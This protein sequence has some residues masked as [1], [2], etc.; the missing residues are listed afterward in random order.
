MPP[1]KSPW[2][3]APDT[4][5]SDELANRFTQAAGGTQVSL[6]SVTIGPDRIVIPP[7]MGA[8]PNNIPLREYE[9]KGQFA[10]FLVPNVYSPTGR[11]MVLAPS[12]FKFVITQSDPAQLVSFH[13]IP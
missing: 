4:V 9:L 13:L 7:H 5:G 12:S 1:G 3:P 8:I 11:A 10:K 2:V 6:T